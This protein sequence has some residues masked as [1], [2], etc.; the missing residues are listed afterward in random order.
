MLN[1]LAEG[2]IWFLPFETDFI[3]WLQSL[4]GRFSFLYYVMNLFSFLGES[5]FIALLVAVIYFGFDK[6]RGERLLLSLST[7]LLTT[8]FVKDLVCR[9]RPFDSG[10]GIQNFRNVGGY[11]FPS[12]H[13][14]NAAAVYGT[15]AINYRKNVGKWLQVL[16]VAVPLLVAL[17]RMYVGAHYPTDVITGL[18][19]GTA[20]A[21]LLNWLVD[22]VPHKEFVFVGAIV[23]T[24]VGL[25]TADDSNYYTM[26][27]ILTGA[28]CGIILEN[29]VVK[30][31]QTTTWWRILLRVAGAFAVMFAVDTLL[32]LPFSK[33]LYYTTERTAEEL[34]VFYDGASWFD[35]IFLDLQGLKTVKHVYADKIVAEK[36]FRTSKYAII[37]FILTGVYPMLFAPCKK[38]FVKIGWIKEEE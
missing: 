36:I 20:Y 27:G 34:A 2:N 9:A 22:V 21:F 12:G 1:L 32:K 3:L 35:K 14:T 37:A 29:R 15:L 5:A 33:S 10:T 8:T 17:S 11:S 16:C 25:F 18:A 4:G 31:E 23:L 6:N 7:A 26:Y 30:F 24:T 38:L 28:T 13:S 19:I